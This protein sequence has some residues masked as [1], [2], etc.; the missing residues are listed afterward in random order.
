MVYCLTT[1]LEVEANRCKVGPEVTYPS[2]SNKV[3][4]TSRRWVLFFGSLL[5]QVEHPEDMKKAQCLL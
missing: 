3:Q 4:V 5:P 2:S 1:E